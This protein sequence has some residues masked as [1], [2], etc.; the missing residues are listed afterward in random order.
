MKIL[1]LVLM[2]AAGCTIAEEYSTDTVAVTN[3][4]LKEFTFV[5]EIPQT[6]EGFRTGLMFR[7]SLDDDKGMLFVFE[8]S[9]PRSFWMKNTVIPLDMLFID[10]NLIVR[11]IHH[12]IPCE[13]DSCPS[14]KSRVPVK[15]VLEIRGNLTRELSIEEGNT[16][17]IGQY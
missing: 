8:D 14:Y 3:S 4:E 15:Y 13:E 5:V 7:E 2:I 10:E 16:V 12:A 1:V 17:E 11:T 9:A 6:A